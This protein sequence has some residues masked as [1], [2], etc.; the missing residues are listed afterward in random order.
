MKS[1][2][3]FQ[4]ETRLSRRVAGPRAQRLALVARGGRGLTCRRTRAE[5]QDKLTPVL[6]AEEKHPPFDIHQVCAGALAAGS[7]LPPF[8]PNDG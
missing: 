4:V 3:E 6:E 7:P 1:A 5:W 8:P 2:E